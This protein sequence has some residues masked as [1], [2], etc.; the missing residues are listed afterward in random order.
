MGAKLHTLFVVIAAGVLL[1]ACQQEPQAPARQQGI[2]PPIGPQQPL[3][4]YSSPAAV[5]PT[6]IQQATPVTQPG[7]P[8]AAQPAQLPETPLAPLPPPVAATNTAPTIRPRESAT[9]GSAQGGSP[10]NAETKAGV[11]A[12]ITRVTV[13]AGPLKNGVV[14]KGLARRMGALK[15][16]YRKALENNPQS[17][18]EVIVPLTIDVDGSVMHSVVAHNELDSSMAKC[19]KRVID[20]ARFPASNSEPSSC[21]ARFSFAVPD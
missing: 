19:V 9:A 4:P 10:T 15:A 2:A 3:P 16:C 7:V 1:A 5:A 18:G 17:Q 13:M 11:R 6:Q 21:E 14:K 20:R 12:R 8:P